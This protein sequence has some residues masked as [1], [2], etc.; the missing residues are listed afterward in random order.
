M[1][2]GL[3]EQRKMTRSDQPTLDGEVVAPTP[4][5]EASDDGCGSLGAL[6]EKKEKKARQVAEE[7]WFGLSPPTWQGTDGL[8][9]PH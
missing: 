7:A 2:T 4:E 5:I 6:L 8:E 1:A 9:F 3:Q